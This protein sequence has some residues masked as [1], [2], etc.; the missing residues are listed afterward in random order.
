M[1]QPICNYLHA[2][3]QL[4]RTLPMVESQLTGGMGEEE[5]SHRVT[6]RPSWRATLGAHSAAI[7]RHPQPTNL[8]LFVVNMVWPRLQFHTCSDV[9]N[10]QLVCLLNLLKLSWPTQPTV[11]S[12][13]CDIFF[14]EVERA[15][16]FRIQDVDILLE[17]KSLTTC[18]IGEGWPYTRSNNGDSC[19]KVQQSLEPL[20]LQSIQKATMRNQPRLFLLMS[21]IARRL[22]QIVRN[23]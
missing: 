15:S 9:S 20:S 13:F 14:G 2:T 5:T 3:Y 10:D 18:T 4:A 6:S 19:N 17:G 7:T 8:Y 21:G 23:G 1:M 16:L 11:W 22:W 12:A